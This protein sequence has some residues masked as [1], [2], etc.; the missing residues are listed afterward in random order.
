VEGAQSIGLNRVLVLEVEGEARRQLQLLLSDEGCQVAAAG[1]VAAAL[2]EL[3]ARSYDAIFCDLEIL[4]AANGLADRLR[5]ADAP[6][7]V[8]LA[9]PEERDVALSA[10]HGAVWDCLLKPAAA[11]DV[12]LAIRRANR[13][14]SLRGPGESQGP[15]SR[16]APMPAPGPMLAGMVGSAPSMQAVFR[17]IQKV[18]QHKANVL[19]TG[20]SGTGKELV[21]RA[22]HSLGPRKDHPFVAIN[23]GAIPETLLES[24][25]FGHVRGAFTDAVRDKTGLFEEADGGTLFLDEIGELSPKL[26]VKLLRAIQ[27]E[28]IRRIGGNTPIDIDVRVISATLLD[29]GV[30]CRTGRF[31]EYLFY[32]LNVLPIALPP[33]RDRREDIPLLVQHFLHRYTE[34]HAAAGARVERVSDEAMR[35][36]GEYAWPG[37]IRELENTIERALVLC[38]GTVIEADLLEEKLREKRDPIRESLATD[39]L[40]IKKTTRVVEEEL[41]RR[42]LDATGGN[43]TNASKLLEISHRAL[44]YKIKEYGL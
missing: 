6:L 30:A 13:L 10:A 38:E 16:A 26:Q 8:V 37:N 7:L 34:K 31:R 43:R 21:A 33:L 17:T 23:C 14:L 1:E 28:E 32:R 36:L 9:D 2:R 15:V 44:L 41:I 35:L 20:E 27:E 12:A 22:M 11:A 42:A 40:S 24:E 4:E 39:E 25:L 18:A 5:A 3:D 29:L 19:I